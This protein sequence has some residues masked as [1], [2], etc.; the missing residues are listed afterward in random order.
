MARHV[1][2]CIHFVLVYVTMLSVLHIGECR[3]TGYL[4]RATGWKAGVLLQSEARDFTLLHSVQTGSETHLGVKRPGREA[5]HSPSS[6]A[7]VKKDGAIPSP[8]HTSPWRGT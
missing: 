2:T 6:S 4:S 1:A 3:Y 7:N 8:P 5:D